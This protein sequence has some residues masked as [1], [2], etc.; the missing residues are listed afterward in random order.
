MKDLHDVYDM[1]LP[2]PMTSGRMNEWLEATSR[3]KEA[4]GDHV[5]IMGRADQGPFSIACLL[6]R[7]NTVYDGS[8]DRG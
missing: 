1:P 4:I 3:L 5:F 8:Y 2:D 7:Y 6:R